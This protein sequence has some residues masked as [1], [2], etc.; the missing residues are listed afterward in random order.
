MRC[1]GATAR[2]SKGCIESRHSRQRGPHDQRLWGQMMRI[3][4]IGAGVFGSLFAARL[5]AVGQTVALVARG[6][7]LTQLQRGPIVFLN[8][9]DGVR[10]AATV[11]VVEHLDP[12]ADYDLA[13]VVVRADQI[14]ALIP[15]LSGNRGVKTFLCMHNRAAG[16]SALARSVGPDR[17]LLGFSGGG[18]WLDGATVRYRLIPEQLTTL[19]E[20]DGSLS[21]RMQQVEKI[22]EEAG[23]PVALSRRT[24][25]WLKTHAMLVTAI[26][27]A[28][29]LGHGSTAEVARSPDNIR[30]LVHGIRQGFGLLSVAGVV[31]APR[32]LRFLVGLPSLLAQLY[33]RRILARPAS[34]LIMARHANAVPGEMHALVKELFVIVRLEQ[35][36]A[37]DLETLWTAVSAA[38]SR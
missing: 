6:G 37:P 2:Q 15:D 18:G 29:Y 30:V 24:D 36:H 8:E 21:P 5:A 12:E 19:G 38:A 17:V 10:A 34:E 7:R 33:L 9:D 22:L 25:D 27:G 4:D 16:S 26:A 3:A 32:R 1:H 11:E 28:I 31:I 13:L 23:F 35:G 20:P 14:D